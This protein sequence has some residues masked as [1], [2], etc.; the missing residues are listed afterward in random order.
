ML[1]GPWCAFDQISL[2]II[3]SNWNH[4]LMV[5]LKRKPKNISSYELI[6]KKQK[7]LLSYFE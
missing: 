7:N 5:S 4:Y 1:A 6:L 2:Q 3:S